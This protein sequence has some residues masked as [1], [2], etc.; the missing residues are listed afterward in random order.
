MIR[1]TSLSAYHSLDLTASEEKIMKWFHANP[2]LKVNRRLMSVYS[3][4]PIN[5]V[6][7]RIN[8]LVAKGYLEELPAEIDQATGKSAHPVRIKP[9]QPSLFDAKLPSVSVAQCERSVICG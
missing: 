9:T 4:I 5:A 7:G 3:G 2:R 6:T 8:S 1:E